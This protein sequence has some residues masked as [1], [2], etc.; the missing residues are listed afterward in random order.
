MMRINDCFF[1]VKDTVLPTLHSNGGQDLKNN[2]SYFVNL[3]GGRR[4][5]PSLEYISELLVTV[6]ALERTLFKE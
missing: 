3:P 2:L 4:E 1:T 5:V 6:A